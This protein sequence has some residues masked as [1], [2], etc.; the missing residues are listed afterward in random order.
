VSAG[1]PGG[2]QWFV[3][4]YKGHSVE[5]ASKEWFLWRRL[6]LSVDGQEVAR[7]AKKG[8]PSKLGI[9]L[10]GIIKRPDGSLT[11]V[12]VRA[13]SVAGASLQVDSVLIFGCG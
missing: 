6:R 2:S 1:S 10:E 7:T 9:T 8:L 4:A 11:P 5:V 13:G 3:I 12:V